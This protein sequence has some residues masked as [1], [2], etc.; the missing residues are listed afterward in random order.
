MLKKGTGEIL[1]ELLAQLIV[2]RKKMI[3]VTRHNVIE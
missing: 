1:H 2:P 3:N